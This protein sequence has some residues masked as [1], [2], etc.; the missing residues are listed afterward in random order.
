MILVYSHNAASLLRFSGAICANTD[1]AG[2]GVRIAFYAQSVMNTLL[3]VLSPRDS[4]PSAWAATLLTGSLIIAAIVQKT[5]QSLTLHHATLVLNFATLSCISSLAAAPMLPIWR[6]RP[7][8]FYSEEL[9]RYALMGADGKEEY[10]VLGSVV[11]INRNKKKI[12]TAQMRGRVVL[13]LAILTQVVLQW[14]WG[15]LMFVSSSYSGEYCSGETKLLFFLVPF[16]GS[17]LDISEGWTFAV[18]PVWLLFSLGITMSLTIILA[19]SSPSRAHDEGSTGMSSTSVATA[20]TPVFMGLVHLTFSG[21]PAWSD[22][23]KQLIF[24]GHVLASALWLLFLI[25]SELQR[26]IN[27]IFEGEN[28]FGGF[29]Q[30]TAVLLSLAP[31]WSLTIAI[32][33]YP[34]RRKREERHRLRA[35]A[36]RERSR[37]RGESVLCEDRASVL[38][39]N[40]S[41][42]H[43]PKAFAHSR[44]TTTGSTVVGEEYEMGE[45]RPTR[46]PVIEAAMDRGR[47][48]TE[49]QTNGSD[50]SQSVTD[51]MTR[52]PHRTEQVVTIPS[53]DMGLDSEMFMHYQVR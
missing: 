11:Y 8:E 38:L 26:T 34:S 33:K 35:A 7:E 3:V 27:P 18:W 42:K 52:R 47:S 19:L 4:V 1:L 44:A 36:Q 9:K 15:I 46:I 51:R 2:I 30:V 14:T 10:N 45:Q 43:S 37:E 22:R 25:S 24:W 31:A 41:P 12:K 17:Q 6:L 49:R 32:Y 28:D 29:G 53:P 40:A 13:S 50:A 21:F 16:K 23:P 48:R 20:T 5:R 39:H